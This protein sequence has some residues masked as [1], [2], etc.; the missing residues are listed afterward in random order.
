MLWAWK[1]T[2][3]LPITQS[4]LGDSLTIIYSHLD[5]FESFKI[6]LNHQQP[7]VLLPKKQKSF[8]RKHIAD[9]PKHR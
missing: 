1:Y 9:P 5:P 4:L 8:P 3:T 6:N 2:A 7:I